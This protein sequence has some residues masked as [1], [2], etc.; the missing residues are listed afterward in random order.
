MTEY[1]I[2]YHDDLGIKLSTIVGATNVAAAIEYAREMFD[3]LRMILDV[4]EVTSMTLGSNGEALV[5]GKM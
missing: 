2:T 1:N 5:N 4:E 3:D